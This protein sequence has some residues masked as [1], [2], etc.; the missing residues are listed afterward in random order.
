MLMGL[1]KIGLS[2]ASGYGL[3]NRI[4]ATPGFHLSWYQRYHIDQLPKLPLTAK[5][6]NN[7]KSRTIPS[8][9][10]TSNTNLGTSRRRYPTNNAPSQPV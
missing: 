3:I 5:T 10:H 2:L 6:G 8:S 9:I 4:K 7:A 1:I